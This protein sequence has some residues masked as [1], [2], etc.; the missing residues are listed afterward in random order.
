MEQPQDIFLFQKGA[1]LPG[2]KCAITTSSSTLIAEPASSPEK[3]RAIDGK[4]YNIVKWGEKNNLPTQIMSSC[5]KSPIV[6]AGMN[7]NCS[8][9]YGDGIIYGRWQVND[10]GKRVFIQDTSNKEINDFFLNNDIDNYI[11]EQAND[12]CWFYNIF[13]EILLNKKEGNI[14]IVG[15][16]HKEA[17]FSRLEEM[18]ADTGLIKNHFYS[19]HWGSATQSN[20][21]IHV[22]PILSPFNTV[23]DLK[24]RMGV[25]PDK[26]G[27]RST[28]KNFR[29]I[30]PINLPTPGR[31]YYQKPYWYSIIESGWLDYSQ[32][33]PEFKNALLENQMVIKYHVELSDDYFKSIF[34]AE[35]ITEDSAKQ[36]RIKKE[37]NDLNRFLSTV[38]NTGK[39]VISFIRYDAQGKELRRMKINVIDN[40]FTGGEYIEDSEEASNIISYGLGVH[41]SLIGSSPGKNKNISGS[42]A[43]ELF[44]IKQSMLRPLRDR[45]LRPLYII[46]AFN[47]WPEDIDFVIPNTTLKT[48]DSGS[49]SERVIS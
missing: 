37:Y 42:E 32:R 19:A 35:K 18:D 2:V 6:T 3:V 27:K 12:I 29:F 28:P 44:I 48:L 5:Y 26:N 43:R 39:T 20:P 33:I 41:P 36:E 24:E 15:L 8:C 25:E 45:L 23:M 47:N 13:P 14:K 34:Q 16:R 22:T 17:A 1:Y 4:S 30:I 7:F 10:N 31:N 11:M 38:K 40:K 49:G 9:T 21:K 46:K